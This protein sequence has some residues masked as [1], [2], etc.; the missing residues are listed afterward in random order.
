M[1]MKKRSKKCILL[2]LMLCILWILPGCQAEEP[3]EPATP[4][5]YDFEAVTEIKE[6]QPDVYV[7][8]KVLT[9][10][11]WQ[12]IVT[13]ITDAGNETGVNVYVSASVGESDWEIQQLLLEEAMEADADAIIL[14]PGNSSKLSEPAIEIHSNGVPVILVDTIL[15][16][17]E[18]FDTCYMTDNLQAGELAAKEMISQLRASG[19]SEDESASIA[20]QITSV[21]S[22]TVIDR[23]AGF[24]QYWSN[25]APKN[26]IVID[27]VKLN[28][29]DSAVAKQNCIDVL[30]AYPDIKGVFGCNNSSTVGFANGLMESGRN[31]VILIG[32]DYADETAQLVASDEWQA[33]TVVQS[34]YNMGYEGLK[35][36]V[37]L[38]NGKG[39]DYKFIDTGTLVINQDNYIIYEQSIAGEK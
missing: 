37:E 27:E 33:S 29:G 5:Y 23:L 1:F 16:D 11:Y 4:E 19:L 36:A 18:S 21:T 26:W 2:V 24:N 15:N 20:I 7:V 31:D 10:Q 3:D 35:T 32:F 39:T 12:D 30:E 17:T 38:I 22:Q 9:S 34:Q 6:G 14:A 28:N 25:N 8:L 13:G